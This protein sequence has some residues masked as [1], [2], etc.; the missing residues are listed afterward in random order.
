[1][2]SASLRLRCALTVDVLEQSLEACI[3]HSTLLPQTLEVVRHY[4]VQDAVNIIDLLRVVYEL[5]SGMLL[6]N[7][8]S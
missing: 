5:G 3:Q 4:R 6:D 7:L 1:M 2:G 8:E